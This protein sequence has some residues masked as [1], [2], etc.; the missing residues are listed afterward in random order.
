MGNIAEGFGRDGNAEFRQFL[1]NAKG[2]ACEVQSHLYVALDA[3]MLGE[4]DFEQLYALAGETAQMIG[5]FIEYL[6]T[7]DLK[8][9]KYR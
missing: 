6:R 4:D 5:G 8:G 9:A 3:E 2:S 7:S 1:S